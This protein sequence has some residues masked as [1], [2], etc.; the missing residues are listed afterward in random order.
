MRLIDADALKERILLERD[1]IPLF[2]P[3]ATYEFVKQ[4]PNKH[5]NAMRGGIRIALRCMENTPTIE[6]ET[7]QHGRILYNVTVKKDGRYFLQP[8]TC[9][10]C[11]EAILPG[12]KY[13]GECG[14]KMDAKEE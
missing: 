6:V 2:T 3:A 9:S 10:K 7:V 4:K 5:G 1:K 11:Y 13:C 8:Y 14:A 12:S